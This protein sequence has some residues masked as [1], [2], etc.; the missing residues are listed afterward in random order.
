MPSAP[1]Q[2]ALGEGG[3]GL[4]QGLELEIVVQAIGAPRGRCRGGEPNGET[5]AEC[6]REVCR[7]WQW[8]PPSSGMRLGARCRGGGP[9][10]EPQAGC[11]REGCHPWHWVQASS[12]MR[13]G[14]QCRGGG[15]GGQAQA[16]TTGRG[17]PCL[18]LAPGIQT[19][20]TGRVAAGPGCQFV[21]PAEPA[22]DVFR[23]DRN[24]GPG[25]PTPEL[26]PRSEWC[27]R[28]YPPWHWVPASKPGRRGG[29]LR[30]RRGGGPPSSR[31][32]ALRVGASRGRSA[33]GSADLDAGRGSQGMP[34]RGAQPLEAASTCIQAVPSALSS[35][36]STRSSSLWASAIP[37]SNASL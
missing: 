32:H 35:N 22:P 12:G 16:G 26:S 10:G 1:G 24:P 31:S 4:E 6:Q 7:P 34:A 37:A 36:A 33:S 14:A 17:L 5:Q 20:T 15:P 29:W 28:A 23:G 13:L 25:R 11:Q 27:Q 2:V 19:G 8:V 30:G 21:I 3:S 9:G 18:A